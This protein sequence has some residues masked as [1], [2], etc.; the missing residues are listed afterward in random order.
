MESS[1][2][3]KMCEN[4]SEYV[5][6]KRTKKSP[7]GINGWGKSQSFKLD[8]DQAH[9]SLG[10]NLWCCVRLRG[11]EGGR[12]IKAAI[13]RNLGGGIRGNVEPIKFLYCLKYQGEWRWFL[14]FPGFSC[15]LDFQDPCHFSW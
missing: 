1:G 10:I 13:C 7:S 4:W 3:K 5:G 8:V 11:R 14:T 12:P 9:R 6:E 15:T 2:W